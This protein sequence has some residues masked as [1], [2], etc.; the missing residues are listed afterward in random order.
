ME[1]G[2]EERRRHGLFHGEAGIPEWKTK[3]VCLVP[4]PSGLAG[5]SNRWLAVYHSLA[6]TGELD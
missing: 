1:I 4:L 6:G 2:W 5:R 3:F